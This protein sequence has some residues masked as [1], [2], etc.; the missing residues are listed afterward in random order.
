MRYWLV[1][2][3]RTAL[4]GMRLVGISGTLVSDGPGA[5]AAIQDACADETVAVLLVTK[6]VERWLPATVA[7]LKLEGRR[8][9][10]TVIPDPGSEGLGSD[11][12]TGLIRDAIGVKI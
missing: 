11:E 1:S 9:L 4:D 5:E 8:P 3:D 10:L 7:R 2:H 12:I 6:T